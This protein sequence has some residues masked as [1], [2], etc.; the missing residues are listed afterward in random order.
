MTLE[1][2][3]NGRILALLNNQKVVSDPY[4]IRIA[5]RSTSSAKLHK[6]K[7]AIKHMQGAQRIVQRAVA[8]SPM[9]S[10]LVDCCEPMGRASPI[11]GKRS[12]RP[13]G[14][15]ARMSKRRRVFLVLLQVSLRA[16]TDNDDEGVYIL[17]R[18]SWIVVHK[19]KTV[20]CEHVQKS[21]RKSL[22]GFLVC[23]RSSRCNL[24]FLPAQSS[25][26]CRVPGS[27][28]PMEGSH[29]RELLS[30]VDYMQL[31]RTMLN[32]CRISSVCRMISFHSSPMTRIRT[33]G[34]ISNSLRLEETT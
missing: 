33:T 23:R 26:A 25:S 4:S 14:C 11:L 24:F 12:A 17:T 31:V 32:I 7:Y 19:S 27:A 28:T 22:Q 18:G 3:V 30:R 29:H 21:R 1:K 16:G 2:P 5:I 15:S 10:R 20:Y 9:R 34:L 13:L 6:A 8:Y